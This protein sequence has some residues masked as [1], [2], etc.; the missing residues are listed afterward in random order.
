MTSFL[1][2]VI[3]TLLGPAHDSFAYPRHSQPSPLATHRSHRCRTFDSAGRG[4]RYS[5]F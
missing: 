5:G 2:F 3:L 4:R 1:I